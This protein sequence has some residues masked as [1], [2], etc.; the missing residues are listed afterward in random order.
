MLIILFSLI[1]I[2]LIFLLLI[3]RTINRD[4]FL[5][6]R[7]QNLYLKASLLSV[8][9]VSIIGSIYF[10]EFRRLEEAHLANKIDKFLLFEQAEKEVLRND[11]LRDV[12]SYVN[13]EKIALENLYALSQKFKLEDEYLISS[14]AYKKIL[15][16]NIE[17]ISGDII[18]EY[19]QVLFFLNKNIFTEEIIE[20]LKLALTKNP[21]EP[22]ALTLNGLRYIQAGEIEKAK[23]E[24][25][26]AIEFLENI[27]EKNVLKA[28]IKN[29]NT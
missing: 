27:Q 4:L 12:S 14:L 5:L 25:E 2:G 26:K 23:K 3:L 10:F 22:L 7:V 15:D 18:A 16:R 19:A 13:N 1:L 9:L 29:L 21:K 11:L 8:I 6:K 24:W 20:I 28:A 17:V